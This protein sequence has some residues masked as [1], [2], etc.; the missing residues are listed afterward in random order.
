MSRRVRC[1][2]RVKV[3]NNRTGSLG[4]T[5]NNKTELFLIDSKLSAS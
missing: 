3:M 2:H 5:R 1:D 4:K